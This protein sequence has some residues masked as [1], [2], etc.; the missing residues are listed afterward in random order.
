MSYLSCNDINTFFEK[1][2]NK[3]TCMKQIYYRKM[4]KG[5]TEYTIAEVTEYLFQHKN[6]GRFIISNVLKYNITVII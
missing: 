6:T 5:T 1:A 3:I 2:N 4:A